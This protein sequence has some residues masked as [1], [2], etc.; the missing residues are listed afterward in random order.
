[1]S[2][3]RETD[4][5]P[6]GHPAAANALPLPIVPLVLLAA[7]VVAA[8]L[9][10]QQVLPA[11]LSALALLLA[12]AGALL[13]GAYWS[14]QRQLDHLRDARLHNQLLGQ[15]IDVWCW[16]TDADHRLT[17][18]QPP[19][20]APASAWVAGA[21]SGECLWQRFDDDLHSLQPRMQAQVPLGELRLNQAPAAGAAP[22]ATAASRSAAK[23]PGAS[24]RSSAPPM[25]PARKTR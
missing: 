14:R 11:W 23:A 9:A 16:Q 5:S 1:M 2:R 13:S 10:S 21:F 17:K 12:T 3:D 19:H 22:R 24:R 7:A 6:T 25:L 4:V 20:A 15:M 18:L 8:L